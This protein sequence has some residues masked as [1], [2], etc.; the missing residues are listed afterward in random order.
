MVDNIDN[1]HTV[2]IGHDV[3][4]VARVAHFIRGSAM[5][6]A[7]RVE[8][9]PARGATIGSVT[10]LVNVEAMLALFE[11]GDLSLQ[12]CGAVF[13]RSEKASG[14]VSAGP[15]AGDS[16]HALD[17]LAHEDGHGLAHSRSG[18]GG[19]GR[20]DVRAPGAARRLRCP[21]ISLR[22]ASDCLATSC[23]RTGSRSSSA[24]PDY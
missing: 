2:G 20:K 23:A 19:E 3:A 8:V 5:V 4:E 16:Q 12:A 1:R 11:P 14:G 9:P 7:G 21:I 15:G 18:G 17:L 22:Q 6:H 24:L 10:K 13:I